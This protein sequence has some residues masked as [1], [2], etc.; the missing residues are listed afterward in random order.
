VTESDEVDEPSR[1][2]PLLVVIAAL[3]VVAL[4]LGAVGWLVTG[5]D[6][7]DDIVDSAAATTSTAPSSTTST[8]DAEPVTEATLDEVVAELSAF[9]AEERGR[10]FK[11]PVAVT[12]LADDAFEARVR[13]D[14]VE[15]VA[16]LEET[17]DVFRALGLLEPGVS[18][19][20]ELQSFLGAGVVGFYD[21]E[22]GELV[23]RGAS[24]TPYV[25]LT[26][27]HELTHAFDDQHFELHRP[28][29]D[30][31]D[32]ERG[33]AFGALV[34]GNALRIEDAY[35]AT[36]TEDERDDADAEEARLSAGIDL[37]D[38]PPV[39]PQL[40]GF[41][42][43]FG[44]MLVEALAD[45]GGEA[46]ID[47]AFGAPPETSE[48]VLDSGTWLAGDAEPV[49]VPPPAADGE[50]IDQGT[51]GLWGLYVIL[52]SEL[53][54][55]EAI[56]AARGWGG[57]WYVAWREGDEVCIRATV[58]MDSGDDLD[59]LASGLDDWAAAQDDASVTVADDSLQLDSCG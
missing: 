6:D 39:L 25:R 4:V 23:V 52:I 54:A 56:Q 33:F 30:D 49:D 45:E 9:V 32:D 11:Q 35:R 41:P 19:V 3:L 28:A 51:L 53:G 26:L 1:R 13:E 5:G 34:E 7:D 36:L 44:P 47:E 29:L 24:L 12:L 31:A 58:V 17:E 46:R 27:V 21:P 14:A 59:D 40:I 20:E 18:L 50:V 37:E 38:V 8:T 22:T 10:E 48:Q 42:Y 16:E 43:A 55:P 15:D 57:D 2:S